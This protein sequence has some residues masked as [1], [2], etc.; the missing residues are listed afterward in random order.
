MKSMTSH[1]RHTPIALHAND[2]YYTSS[3]AHALKR[4]MPLIQDHNNIYNQ[5]QQSIKADQ[6]QNAAIINS[7]VTT[8]TNSHVQTLKQKKPK[9]ETRV[10]NHTS[11]MNNNEQS[12]MTWQINTVDAGRY[13]DYSGMAINSG[14]DELADKWIT[15]RIGP[16]QG[17]SNG[18]RKWLQGMS[19]DVPS[20]IMTEDCS[21]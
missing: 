16:I 7:S 4:T 14:L 21:Y 8:S 18:K 12:H 19:K 1:L 15:G 13:T 3:I 11:N 5:I 2:Q 9:Q 6:Q 20:R 10:Q 17:R